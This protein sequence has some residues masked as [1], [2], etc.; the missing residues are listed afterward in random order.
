M[1]ANRRNGLDYMPLFNFLI[2]R[3]GDDWNEIYSAAIARLDR[4]DPIFWLVARSEAEKRPF[5]RV[6]ESSYYSGFFINQDNRLARVDPELRV[7]DMKPLC[8][9]CTHT[10][11]G[12]PYVRKF[13]SGE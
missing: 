8:A 5:V 10:F 7:E 1:H 11:N 9:C 6:G 13:E 2:S 4:P 12:V 3:V